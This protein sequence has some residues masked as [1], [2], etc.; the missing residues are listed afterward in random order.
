MIVALLDRHL[1]TELTD[2]IYKM[3]HQSCMRE[4][5]NIIKYKMVFILENTKKMSFLICEKQ[6]YYYVLNDE[7]FM[8]Q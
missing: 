4:V 8:A 1:P 2:K 5:C 3:F 7:I 6:N